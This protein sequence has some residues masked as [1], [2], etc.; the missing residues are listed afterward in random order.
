VHF[1]ETV[2]YSGVEEDALGSRRLPSIDVRHDSNVA[3]SPNINLPSH[4]R[5]NR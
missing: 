4:R 5:C 3:H 1:T 2:R